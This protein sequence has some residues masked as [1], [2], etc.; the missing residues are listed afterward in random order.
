MENTANAPF[1]ETEKTVILF[2]S[3][4]SFEIDQKKRQRLLH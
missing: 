1:S 4:V 2:H 3:E